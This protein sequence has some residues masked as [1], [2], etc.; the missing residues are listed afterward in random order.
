M[1]AVI[2]SIIFINAFLQLY[3]I[4]CE[5]IEQYGIRNRALSKISDHGCSDFSLILWMLLHTSLYTF[6]ISNNYYALTSVAKLVRVLSHKLKCHGLIPGQGTGL[7]FRLSPQSGC[8][9]EVTNQCFSFTMIFP[10]LFPSFPLS[11][12]SMGG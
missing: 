10:F 6:E 2:P 9:Q 12:K 7:G 4:I 5:N 3:S 8:I 11:L 1:L